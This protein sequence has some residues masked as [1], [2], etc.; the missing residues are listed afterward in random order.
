MCNRTCRDLFPNEPETWCSGCTTA[1]AEDRE[2]NM[3]RWQARVRYENLQRWTARFAA[4][5]EDVL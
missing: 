3:H 1:E 4:R 2:A 5:Q